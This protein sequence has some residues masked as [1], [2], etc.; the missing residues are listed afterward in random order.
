MI[1]IVLLCALFA[2]FSHSANIDALE[3][4]VPSKKKKIGKCIVGG[5][6]ITIGSI[7]FLLSLILYFLSISEILPTGK[8]DLDIQVGFFAFFIVFGNYIYTFVPSDICTWKKVC[9]A[10]GYTLL[11]IAVYLLCFIPSFWI[12]GEALFLFVA[13][14]VLLPI[15]IFLIRISRKRAKRIVLPKQEKAIKNL[16]NKIM[17][18]IEEPPLNYIDTEKITIKRKKS[19]TSFSLKVNIA[20]WIISTLLLIACIVLFVGF[21]EGDND[22]LAPWLITS[23]LVGICI[24]IWTWLNYTRLSIKH[25]EKYGLGF[26]ISGFLTIISPFSTLVLLIVGA[27]FCKR[28]FDNEQLNNDLN[29]ID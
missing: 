28:V 4:Y 18:S 16:E 24:A 6:L 21:V 2:Y 15:S 17:S 9:K 8:N 10:V 29:R 22:C 3:G 20:G 5:V 25:Y 1:S 11:C 19:P 12:N 7:G 27:M 14:L 23:F 26:L 13:F